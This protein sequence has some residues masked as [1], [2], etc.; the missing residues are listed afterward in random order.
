[1]KKGTI[2]T[3]I[4]WKSFT[5]TNHE[6]LRLRSALRTVINCNSTLGTV[7]YFQKYG[8]SLDKSWRTAKEVSFQVGPRC[9]K[10]VSSASRVGVPSI[11]P[12]LPS[13][14]AQPSLTT[15]CLT[16]T[17]DPIAV[18]TPAPAFRVQKWKWFSSRVHRLRERSSIYL[19]KL[20][21]S[22]ATS[23]DRV[24]SFSFHNRFLSRNPIDTFSNEWYR[25]KLSTIF[26]VKTRREPYSSLRVAL[27]EKLTAQRAD[28]A[29]NRS[30]WK[31]VQFARMITGLV[32]IDQLHWILP[33]RAFHVSVR[34]S[35][36]HW[37]DL[38]DM[39]L[40]R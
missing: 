6:I 35:W 14:E 21:S 9:I 36:N 32:E 30:L 7:Q 23:L 13:P 11:P 31:S 33:F 2:N 39:H 20:I 25:V 34:A 40:V 27:D 8:G 19:F 1:M 37:P 10:N 18:W 15:T 26:P 28:R 16:L 24:Y 29:T 3:Y 22:S 17:I 12:W 4:L 38:R 5:C